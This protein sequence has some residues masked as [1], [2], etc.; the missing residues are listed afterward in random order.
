[1]AA[2]ARGAH[3]NRN[4]IPSKTQLQSVTKRELAACATTGKFLATGAVTGDCA[5]GAVGALLRGIPGSS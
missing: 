3:R 4:K 5:D 2:R 1:M